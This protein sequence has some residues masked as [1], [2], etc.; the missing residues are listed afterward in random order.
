MPVGEE[1]VV[2]VVV[3]QL[4]VVAAVEAAAVAPAAAKA[5]VATHAALGSSRFPGPEG[6][7]VAQW[8]QF[9]RG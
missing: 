2:L 1:A 7:G 9:T 5:A 8:A 6:G 3:V 4:A